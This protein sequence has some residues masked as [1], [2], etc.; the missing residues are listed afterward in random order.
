[1]R[2]LATVG[3]SV[4]PALRET[5]ALYRRA[6]SGFAPDACITDFD[7]FSHVFGLLFDR[8]VISIDHQHVVD[9]CRHDPVVRR[10]LP[11][12]DYAVTKAVVRAKLPGCRH[13]VVSSFYFP[14]LGRDRTTLVGPILRREI[15]A[16]SPHAGDHV[17]VYQTSAA[18]VDVVAALRALPRVRFRVYARGAIADTLGNIELRAFDEQRFLDDLASARAVICNGG[19]TLMSEALFL[20]KPVLSIPIDHQGE[21]QLN[22]AYLDVLGLGRCADRIS[23]SSIEDFIERSPRTPRIPCGNARAFATIDT[24]LANVS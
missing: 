20:G 23:S 15:L 10:R 19:Y 4:R 6:I 2:T 8:P 12:R 21:Q 3:R 13:Y 1:M 16:L 24:L 17:L 14:D 7:S 11:R 18:T 5:I 22:A 9:R